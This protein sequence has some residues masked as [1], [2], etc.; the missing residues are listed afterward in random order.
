MSAITGPSRT[1][2]NSGE[3]I[4]TYEPDTR[5]ECMI[6]SAPA[7]PVAEP[8][9]P[10]LLHELFER[11]A[12]QYPD[13]E[14]LVTADERLTYGQLNVR[15][16]QLAHHLR[17]LGVG[18]EKPVGVF[19]ERTSHVVV[20]LLGVLKSGGAYVPLDPAYP[21]A[22]LRFML[23]DTG[24][25][26]VVTQTSLVPALDQ[27]TAGTSRS[28]TS[29]AV[30]ADVPAVGGSAS[31]PE[32]LAEATD[33][34]Y[35]IYT[36]GSTGQPKGVAL[37]HRNAV[38]FVHWA[39]TW[40]KRDE[41]AGVLASTSICFDVSMFEIFATL[42]L[43][44]RVILAANALE[45][46][47]LP[48][49]EDVRMI[50]TSPSVMREI[51]RMGPLPTSVVSFALA[52]EALDTALVRRLYALPGVQ[53]VYDL[54]G[55]TETTTYSTAAL[56]RPDPTATI[57][58]PIANTTIHLL[59]EMLQPVPP[60]EK[61][62]IYIGGAGVA[63][64][65]LHRPDLTAQKFIADPFSAEP[66]ARL[67]RTGDLGRRRP[68]GELEYLGRI[69]HQVKIHGFR[70]EPGEIE[71]VLRG[72][73]GVGEAVVLAREDQPGDRRLVAYIVPLRE[74]NAGPAG[75]NETRLLHELRDIIHDS[76]PHYMVPG[77]FVFLERLPLTPNGKLD[78]AALPRP[79]RLRPSDTACVAPTTPVEMTLCRLWSQA[80]DVPSVGMDDDFLQLGGD[81]LLAVKLVLA[82]EKEF[83]LK[84][85][86]GTILQAPTVA[87]FA[88]LIE[89][90]APSAASGAIV[91]LQAGSRQP[92]LFLVHGVGGGMLWGY[93]N[94]ARNLAPDQPVYTFQ[95]TEPRPEGESIVQLARRYVRELKG[96]QP[97]GPYCLG[98][99]CFGGN[100]AFE[101]A[102]QLEAEGASVGLVLLFNSTPPN[103]EYENPRWSPGLA[104]R[105]LINVGRW[106]GRFGAWDINNQRRF[107]AWKS[108]TL[109]QHAVRIVRRDAALSSAM[110]RQTEI[111]L[112]D[113]RAEDRPLWNAHL[114]A[115]RSHNHRPFGGRVALLRTSTHQFLCS[116]DAAFGWGAYAPAGVTVRIVPGLHQS[117]LQEP[118][119]QVIGREVQ[120]CLDAVAGKLSPAL[121]ADR[122]SQT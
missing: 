60:G 94:L 72:H 76:L 37:E 69:D 74:A 109:W 19:A 102:G 43:G 12:A 55:P 64:G 96:F 5:T 98:G 49:R 32:P 11:H 97:E 93:T 85:A 36:S 1:P 112:A 54:Y 107:L 17:T 38:A 22:R 121:H 63:R 47:L 117:M 44:G 48:A 111:N 65:Y 62:E 89:K 51:L 25:E 6:G 115:R 39:G 82:V 2:S 95:V 122:E 21:A 100:L 68:N 88:G 8:N 80:L 91:E 34:A 41:L 73:P 101:M 90:R 116:F 40:F 58:R 77:A 119:V 52:G 18:R 67:Y 42:G 110:D 118:H 29:V 84:L 113:V 16:N 86:P 92:A 53:R 3:P 30:D 26:I 79:S 45:L 78:R 23:Q 33:L 106:M 35:V 7:P 31:N 108:R 13:A 99:F 50:V 10:S 56:R 104:G 20:A 120:A 70:I 61:G 24:A 4:I 46:P 57:G 66:G 105:F 59:D 28:L 14:A 114:E 81:S 75:P 9:A 71:A 83:A 103:S 15:A 87:K 27:I